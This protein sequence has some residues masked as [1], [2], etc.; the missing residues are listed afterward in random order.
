MVATKVATPGCRRR[1][2]DDAVGGRLWASKPALEKR[3]LYYS[4]SPSSLDIPNNRNS[5]ATLAV[6]CS[7][8]VIGVED[9][10]HFSVNRPLARQEQ[11]VKGKAQSGGRGRSSV[12]AHVE[13]LGQAVFHGAID[14]DFV[15]TRFELVFEAV[16]QVRHALHLFGKFALRDGAVVLGKANLDEFAMGSSNMPS[17]FGAVENP[18]QRRGSNAVL[19]PG[20][21]SRAERS[22]RLAEGVEIADGVWD[23]L[24]DLRARLRAAA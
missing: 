14:E 13:V 23:S 3:S 17:A 7:G 6:F 2:I 1:F 8:C 16:T 19:V 20:D 10:D 9:R 24:Q 21:R 5:F 18:W 15:E 22:R 12:Q 4:L 11:F